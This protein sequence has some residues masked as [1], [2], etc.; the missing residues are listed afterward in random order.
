MLDWQHQQHARQT[1]RLIG[2]SSVAVPTPRNSLATASYQ[3]ETPGVVYQHVVPAEHRLPLPLLLL[4][5]VDSDQRDCV[6]RDLVTTFSP[7]ITDLAINSIPYHSHPNSSRRRKISP[8][9]LNDRMGRYLITGLLGRHQ[10]GTLV[11]KLAVGFHASGYLP[12]SC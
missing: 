1:R 12:G 9:S 2:T 10:A 8:Q 11:V 3:D 5:L 7:S 4:L 6:H